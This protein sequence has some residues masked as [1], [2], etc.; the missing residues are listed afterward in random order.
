MGE[1]LVLV[2]ETG[3][4]YHLIRNIVSAEMNPNAKM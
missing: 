1:F 3:F 4:G 2:N